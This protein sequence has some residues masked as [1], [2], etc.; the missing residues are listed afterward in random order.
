MF[1]EPPMTNNT[2]MIRR[3]ANLGVLQSVA[4]V[5]IAVVAVA[6]SCARL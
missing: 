2:L 6:V 1:Y 3:L 4:V 5:P